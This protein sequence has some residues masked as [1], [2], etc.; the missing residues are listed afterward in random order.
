MCEDQSRSGSEMH[1]GYTAEIVAQD[2][3]VGVLVEGHAVGAVLAESH[4]MTKSRPLDFHD[5]LLNCESA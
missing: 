1:E 3:V 2:G 4:S 5:A